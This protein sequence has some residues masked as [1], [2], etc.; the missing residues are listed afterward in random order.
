M[1]EDQRYIE[2]AKASLRRLKSTLEAEKE[3]LDMEK[4]A[5]KNSKIIRGD[6]PMQEG[7]EI[8]Q[9][10]KELTHQD[11]SHYASVGLESK[12]SSKI[13]QY[14]LEEFQTIH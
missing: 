13:S 11:T 6:K 5:G 8:D 4:K 10:T 1:G 12:P 7:A 3:K 14:A 2:W 9:P